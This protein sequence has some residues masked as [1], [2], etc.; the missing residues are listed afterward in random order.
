MWGS[1][2]TRIPHCLNNYDIEFIGSRHGI[3][4]MGEVENFRELCDTDR[5]EIFDSVLYP[6]DQY[7][8]DIKKNML[9][10][11]S[12]TVDCDITYMTENGG[13]YLVET[14]Y[15]IHGTVKLELASEIE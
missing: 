6:D 3:P 10:G 11:S 7:D 1:I 15:Y 13:W 4:E 8:D 5:I 12:N 2:I 9:D 14:V